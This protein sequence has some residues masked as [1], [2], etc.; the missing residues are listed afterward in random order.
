M[1]NG[2]RA[3][4]KSSVI[5]KGQP[6]VD[7]DKNRQALDS[8]GGFDFYIYKRNAVLLYFILQEKAN[9]KELCGAMLKLLT[10]PYECHMIDFL[11]DAGNYFEMTQDD[12]ALWK[13]WVLLILSEDDSIFLQACK[14]VLSVI[15]Q[16]PDVVTNL[17][18]GHLAMFE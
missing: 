9:I 10:K 16:H 17:T 4:R 3:V 12:F 2:K 18:G 7:P 5:L 6:P 13:G 11:C 8:R 15:M 1:K 14:D